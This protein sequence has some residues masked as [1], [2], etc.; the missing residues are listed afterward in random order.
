MSVTRPA[1]LGHH[2][3]SP[4]HDPRSSRG[5]CRRAAGAGRPRL[6]L[7]PPRRT[8]SGCPGARVRP[9][10]SAR[11][12]IRAE[13]PWLLWADSTDSQKRTREGSLWGLTLHGQGGNPSPVSGA[14]QT[15]G[16]ADGGEHGA[17]ATI[18]RQFLAQVGATQHGGLDDAVQDEGQAD[19]VLLPAQEALGA[20]DGVQGPEARGVG[21]GAP[22]VD[23]A[24]GRVGVGG[25]GGPGSG[26]GQPAP[27]GLRCR[28]RAGRP[29]P[30]RR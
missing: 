17:G 25:R 3:H 16:A 10:G 29:N 5:T 13:S 12:A 20:V 4:R 24:A 1:G 7:G 23:P 8:W 27:A 28:P 11:S 30:P 6:R 2:Q 19:G 18:P 21:L 15:P 22:Q 14:C 9:A 26:A